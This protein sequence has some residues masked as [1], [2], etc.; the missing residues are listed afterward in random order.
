MTD[1][2]FTKGSFQDSANNLRVMAPD[3]IVR[4][5]ANGLQALDPSLS[6]VG[7]NANG[8]AAMAPKA[9]SQSRQPTTSEPPKKN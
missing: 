7:N 4:K 8:L 6:L 5:S 2:K 3:S 1:K 9:M